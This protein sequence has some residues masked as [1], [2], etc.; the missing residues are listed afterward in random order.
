[1]HTIFP[2]GWKNFDTA[3]RGIVLGGLR[4]LLHL[5]AR[6]GAHRNGWLLMNLGIIISS[7]GGLLIWF[8]KKRRAF[9]KGGYAAFGETPSSP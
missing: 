8:S 9:Q 1:M 4:D 3:A 6:E 2:S 7:F 5:L